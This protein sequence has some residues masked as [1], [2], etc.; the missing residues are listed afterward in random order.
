M[1]LSQRM[2]FGFWLLM[3]VEIT[4][5]GVIAWGLWWHTDF[6]T[7]TRLGLLGL[8]ILVLQ[9]IL[10]CTASPLVAHLSLWRYHPETEVAHRF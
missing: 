1:T 7:L 2:W 6:D 4:A 10:A 9:P 3:T 5:I 8:G